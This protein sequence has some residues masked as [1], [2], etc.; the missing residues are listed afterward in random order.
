MKTS[1]ELG[2]LVFSKDA[3]SRRIVE[4]HKQIVS[5][6]LSL[7]WNIVQTQYQAIHFA[8]QFRNDLLSCQL[9]ICN[10]IVIWA[11]N[12]WFFSFFRRARRVNHSHLPKIFFPSGK[13]QKPI[14]VMKEDIRL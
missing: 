12:L 14:I 9:F 13:T 2:L 4:H 6:P 11:N 5:L 3:E 7:L 10:I 1:E 8:K